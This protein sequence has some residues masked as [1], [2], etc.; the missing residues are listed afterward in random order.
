MNSFGVEI[1]RSRF[2]TRYDWMQKKKK[3]G[4]CEDRTHDLMQIVIGVSRLSNAKHT[5]YQ[6]RQ[7]P[8][9]LLIGWD[10]N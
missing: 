3:S 9:D 10:R 4:D 8:S 6:L 2:D 5:R 7:V 1:G